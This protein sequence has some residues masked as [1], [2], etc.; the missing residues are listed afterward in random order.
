MN[1]P[2]EYGILSRQVSV[3]VS[4][5]IA[6]LI[7]ETMAA[8][9]ADC[10]LPE[11]FS[12]PTQ[13]ESESTEK[14]SKNF[15][16]EPAIPAVIPTVLT[17]IALTLHAHPALIVLLAGG[18]S[19]IGTQLFT[20]DSKAAQNPSA[21]QIPQIQANIVWDQERLQTARE[22]ADRKLEELVQSLNV[23]E[24]KYNQVLDVSK[25]RGFGEWIQ[26][27]WVYCD[28]NPDDPNLQMLRG[29][30]MSRLSCMEIHVYD[31]P[32]LNENGK[33][34]VPFQ[35]YLIDRRQGDAYTEVTVPAVYSKKA[36]LAR[37]EIK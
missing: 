25:D 32:E 4:R 8:A 31:T 23:I 34:D 10:I 22:T 21:P 7:D 1:T 30:L 6:D 19:L 2:N 17:T 16:L 13:S 12:A 28:K 24:E 9:H 29:L 18:G 33:P 37:G 20:D 35:D 27:F 14:K 36:L 26:Q 3:A 5:I 11:C 15:R